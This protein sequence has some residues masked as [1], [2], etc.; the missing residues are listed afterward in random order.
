MT[1]RVT[2]PRAAALPAALAMWLLLLA[3]PAKASPVQVVEAEFRHS[4]GER[5]RVS[6]T[7][8][9]AD[10]GWDHYADVWRVKA[11]DGTVLGTRELLHPHVEEQPFT[12]SQ[13]MQ[14]PADTEQVRV[15]AG[16]NVNGINSEPLH[17]D[18]TRSRG[19]GYRVIR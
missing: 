17:V 16:D 19:E 8:R 15:V 7:L 10:S 11:P 1:R 13:T 3:A 2:L 6:V 4:G 12:R 14:I 5:W 9:H 18:L